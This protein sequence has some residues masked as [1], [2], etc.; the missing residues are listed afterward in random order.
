[1]PTDKILITGHRGLLGSAIVQELKN[2]GYNTLIVAAR[3]E[4]DLTDEAKTHRFLKEAKPDAVIHCAALVGGIQANLAR[5]AD[6]LEQNLR[7]Q[8]NV[9]HGSHLAGVPTLIFFGSNCMYPSGAPQ[10]MKE[11]DLLQGPMEPSNLAY[12]TA[13]AAG[14]IECQTHCQQ[15]GRN[16]ITLIPASLYGPHDNF[17]VNTCHVTPALLLRM[18]QAKKLNEP[19]FKVWGT[20]KPRRELLHSQDAARGVRLILEKGPQ[21]GPLNLGAGSDFTV[22]EIAEEIKKTVG[23]TGK[24]VFDTLKPDGSMRKLLDS[25]RIFNLGFKPQMSLADGLQQTYKWLLSGD[26]VRGVPSL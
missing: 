13:K 20:G 18:H 17:D 23:Y 19:E 2:A 9:I 15:Y 10:P 11:E 21:T 24:L 1:M 7:M 5:P 16:Y 25:S 8:T 4:L 3:S 6:F 12:G 26:K 22:A 14:F